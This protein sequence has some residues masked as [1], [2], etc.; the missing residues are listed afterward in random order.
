MFNRDDFEKFVHDNMDYREKT[1]ELI[2]E[3][4]NANFFM[5]MVLTKYNSMLDGVAKEFDKIPEYD[6][7]AQMMGYTTLE[8]TI[9]PM[10]EN[11]QKL[12]KEIKL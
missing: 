3:A 8:A 12:A 2:K 9:R 5:I 4:K 6:I 11:T 10:I 1:Q 7:L